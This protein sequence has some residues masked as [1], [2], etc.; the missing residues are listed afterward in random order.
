MLMKITNNNIIYFLIAIDA[1]LYLTGNI[2]PGFKSVG[3]FEYVASISGMSGCDQFL[4]YSW[5][6]VIFI[7]IISWIGL[8]FYANGA[9]SL[10]ASS[11][12]ICAIS[13]F[14]GGFGSWGPGIYDMVAGAESWFYG[15][16]LCMIFFSPLAEKFNK[17]CA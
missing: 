2:I 4:A 13:I 9:R 12:P 1:L 14:V 16:F 15:F 3:L 17:N 8:A 10:F 11:V 5:I 7:N 6:L